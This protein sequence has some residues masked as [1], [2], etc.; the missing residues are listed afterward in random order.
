MIPGET[1]LVADQYSFWH[2]VSKYHLGADSQRDAQN[3]CLTSTV[4]APRQRCIA[5]VAADDSRALEAYRQAGYETMVMNG[6]RKSE[7]DGLIKSIEEILRTASPRYLVLMTTDPAFVRLCRS[8]NGLPHV[9]LAVWGPA[10]D[11]PPELAQSTCNFRPLEEPVPCPRHAAVD[12]RLD[13]ENLH[14]GL[15]KL[16][17]SPR[18]QKVCAGHPRPGSR[19]WTRCYRHGVRRL[20][21]TG[22]TRWT[23]ST[24][25]AILGRCGDP[26]SGQYPRNKLIR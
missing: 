13:F 16:G 17:W 21:L 8:A 2:T 5:L 6:N 4:F 24:A 22:G 23:G 14:V 9:N 11:T 3:L 20:G 19:V 10:N 25:R 1:I 15:R 12:V 7:L 18:C 26:L